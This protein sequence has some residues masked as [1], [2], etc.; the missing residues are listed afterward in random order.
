LAITEQESVP[1]IG[2]ASALEEARIQAEFVNPF[3]TTVLE[4]MSAVASLERTRT[5]ANR[6]ARLTNGRWAMSQS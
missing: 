1:G 5:R 4:V 2:V 3:P 6:S